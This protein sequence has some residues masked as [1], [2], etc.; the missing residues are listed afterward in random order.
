M[1]LSS[2]EPLFSKIGLVG[3]WLDNSRFVSVGLDGGGWR[4]FVVWL[5]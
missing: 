4:A 5:F 2:E 3:I 1:A